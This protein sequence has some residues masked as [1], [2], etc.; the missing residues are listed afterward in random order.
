MA[1]DIQQNRFQ[2]IIIEHLPYEIRMLRYSF[3][4]LQEIKEGDTDGNAFVE[5]FCIHARNLIDFFRDRKPYSDNQACA[6]HFTET[7]YSPFQKGE[8][9]TRLYDKVNKQIAHLTYHR[10]T[11]EKDKIGQADRNKLLKILQDEIALF[12]AQLK[13]EYKSMWRP[14]LSNKLVP[15]PSLG[16]FNATTTNIATISVITLN[17][18]FERK[19]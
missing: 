11:H 15:L 17:N 6:H 3:S 1:N 9:D 10:S 5:C 16:R 18:D 8:I 14:D 12:S 19:S 4:R 13:P 7:T 2:Q